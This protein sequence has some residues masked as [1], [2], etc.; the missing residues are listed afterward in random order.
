M[1]HESSDIHGLSE[2]HIL[3]T[4]V[5]GFVGQAVL[6]RLLSGSDA[7]I[8]LLIR[9]RGAKTGAARLAALLVKPVFDPWR[10]RVGDAHVDRAVAE[11]V[12]VIEGDLRDVP[13][14]PDDIDTVIHSASSVSFDDPIDKAFATNV[15]GPHALYTALASSGGSTGDAHVVHLSTSYVST[16]RVDLAPE[17]AVEHDVDWRAELTAA[18]EAR[19]RLADGHT[20]HAELTAALRQA[21]RE[22]AHALGWTDVYTMTKSLGE[23]VAEDL[24]AGQGHRLTILRPTIIESALRYPFPGWMDGFKVADPLIAAYAQGRLLGFPGQPDSVLD[25]I[26]VDFVVNAALAAARRPGDPGRAR[27][28]QVG[29]GTSNP[30]S[31][32]E[33]RHWVQDYFSSH[34]WIDRDGREVRPEP[35]EFSDPAA[36]HRWAARRQRA[37]RSSAALLDA[38][39]SHWL[40]GSRQ[41]VHDGLRRLS[42]MRGYVELYQPYTCATTVYDDTQT[43]T[44]LTQEHH[45]R[46]SFDVTAIDWRRYL[47]QGHLPALVAIMQ[48]RSGTPAR[49]ATPER[50][51]ATRPAFETGV[52]ARASRGHG[53]R[54]SAGEAG[55]GAHPKRECGEAG[56]SVAGYVSRSP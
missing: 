7:R 46:D 20:G 9:P 19:G 45:P 40:S 31:L 30:L 6:E 13:T 38:L 22:R 35:W 44:L 43:R 16:G 48:G 56:A 32:A 2:P 54:S 26:P 23:R 42:T 55:N 33:L 10:R 11:R 52:R 17:R 25:V 18:L 49:P 5:T 51:A 28:L 53:G 34:P 8:C 12:T 1:P 15:G 14:L 4:G 3:L 36:L 37:L 47:M 24:W 27:Y 41:A 29:S 39:P 50:A 21:G